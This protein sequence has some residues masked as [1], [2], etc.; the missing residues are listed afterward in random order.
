MGMIQRSRAV[1]GNYTVPHFTYRIK[2]MKCVPK[3][4]KPSWSKFNFYNYNNFGLE[5]Y[6]DSKHFL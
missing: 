5:Q 3:W 1:Q 2:V 6:D 4:T